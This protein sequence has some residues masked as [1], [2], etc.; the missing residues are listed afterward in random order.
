MEGAIARVEVTEAT[1]AERTFIR[2]V[3]PLYLHDLSPFTEFYEL[4]ENGIWFPDYLPDWLDLTSPL[5]HPMLI[6]AGGTNE[7]L[8]PS[9]YAG[10]KACGYRK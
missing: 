7:K 4:D 3:Y 8:L 6:R 1:A 10:L 2:N 5:V 9:G